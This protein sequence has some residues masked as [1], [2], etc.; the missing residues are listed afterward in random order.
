MTTYYTNNNIKS[1]QILILK[2][3]SNLINYGKRKK[4]YDL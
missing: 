4:V 3:L 1:I 2:R